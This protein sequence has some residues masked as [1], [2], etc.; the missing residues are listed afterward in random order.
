MCHSIFGFQHVGRII[1]YF[2]FVH[3]FR[4]VV[5]DVP[6]STDLEAYQKGVE[7][8][9]QSFHSAPHIK[10]PIWQINKFDYDKT[11]Q[12]GRFFFCSG[13]YTAYGGS[14][15]ST[16]DL[17]LVYS[18]EES[19]SVARILSP[20]IFKGIPVL[21][22]WATGGISIW[23]QQY[24]LLYHIQAQ[25]PAEEVLPNSHEAYFTDNDTIVMIHDRHVSAD[26]SSM[27]GDK[28]GR[29][30]QNWIQ[31]IDPV[32]NEVLFEW[33]MTD[34]FNVSDTIWPLRYFGVW[35][36]NTKKAFDYSHMNSVQKVRTQSSPSQPC[37]KL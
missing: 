18:G 15:F 25:G 32:T 24:K 14:I 3:I 33:K 6:H 11:D 29:I 26:L 17:S 34:H 10:A 2:I 4:G 23:S 7:Q 16:K 21:T 8:P 31:E 19:N 12:S 22:M 36:L 37:P 9:M 27:G 1:V 35:D 20:Q 28:K 5:A 13:N 30:V